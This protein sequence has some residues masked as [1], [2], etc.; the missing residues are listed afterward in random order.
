MEVYEKIIAT[1]NE[2]ETFQPDKVIA[3]DHLQCEIKGPSLELI[4]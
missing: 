2:N 1:P 3:L 4:Y